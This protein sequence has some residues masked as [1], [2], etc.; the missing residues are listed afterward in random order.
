MKENSDSLSIK[1]LIKNYQNLIVL[2]YYVSPIQK[3]HYVFACF[4]M[5][6]L[7]DYG[8]VAKA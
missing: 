8:F 7:I 1:S 2:C 5:L 6:V 3:E 4:F